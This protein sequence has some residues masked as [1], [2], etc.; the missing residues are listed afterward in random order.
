MNK[1]IKIK[2]ANFQSFYICIFQLLSL[3]KT[4]LSNIPFLKNISFTEGEREQWVYISQKNEQKL[5]LQA[6]L[7]PNS[8]KVASR[9]FCMLRKCRW[10]VLSH[11]RAGCTSTLPGG[12]ILLQLLLHLL[13]Q[14]VQCGGQSGGG[15]ALNGAQQAEERLLAE[16]TLLHSAHQRLQRRAAGICLLAAATHNLV[17]QQHDTRLVVTVCSYSAAT[18][19]KGF[20]ASSDTIQ[21]HIVVR[22]SVCQQLSHSEMLMILFKISLRLLVLNTNTKH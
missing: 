12:W 10:L 5:M 13:Q 8:Y 9:L 1:E 16:T 18:L 6:A 19:A 7:M 22:W 14:W 4:T 17:A 21:I 2:K 20:S 15:V 11:H 3:L